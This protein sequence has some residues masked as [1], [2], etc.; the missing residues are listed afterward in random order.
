MRFVVLI[1]ALLAA[2]AASATTGLMALHRLDTALTGIVENDMERLLAITHTRRLFRSMVVLERDYIL[3]KTAPERA[4]MDTKMESLAVELQQQLHKY[5]G[6]DA[7]S[8][9][10]RW[11]PASARRLHAGKRSMNAC[12]RRRSAIRT[13]R[14]CCPSNTASTPCRGRS[15][16]VIWS[17]SARHGS[18]SR[19]RTITSCIAPPSLG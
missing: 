3:A 15:R 10:A 5:A 13:R 9:Y 12:A 1:A 6:S 19:P 18:P 11:S 16:S 14:R 7:E 17:S 2:V 4:K 8:G